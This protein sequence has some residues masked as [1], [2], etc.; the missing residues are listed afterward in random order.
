MEMVILPLDNAHRPQ[1]PSMWPQ[2]ARRLTLMGS[3]HTVDLQVRSAIAQIMHGDVCLACT[4]TMHLLAIR[5][6]VEEGYRMGSKHSRFGRGD[7][8]E[9]NDDAS[10]YSDGSWRGGWDE[11]DGKEWPESAAD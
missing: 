11:G 9:R 4:C 8:N 5:C 2:W 6:Y 7:K 1:A 10:Q 3:P